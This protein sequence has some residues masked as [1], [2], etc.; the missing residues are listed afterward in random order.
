MT[1]V[2]RATILL[3]ATA[4]AAGCRREERELA[5]P[6]AEARRPDARHEASLA[7][8]AAAAPNPDVSARPD[9]Q[10]GARAQKNAYE[11]N[12]GQ[13]LYQWFNC[14]GCHG[15]GG[16][17]DIG[18]A[19]RDGQWLY[20][21]EP[22]AI[23][24]SIVHGRPNGMPAFGGKIPEQQLWQ[25]VAYVRSL[26]AMV[27]LDVRPSRRDALSTGAVPAQQT[28]EPPHPPGGAPTP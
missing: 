26:S 3:L 10:R 2:R 4:A 21:G 11:V 5:T 6:A 22:R 27:P 19:L 1:S 9:L 24:E 15:P 8:G 20:G 7:P 12:E 13:R 18:P 17:G 25:L 23:Y 16:G 14:A 28:P